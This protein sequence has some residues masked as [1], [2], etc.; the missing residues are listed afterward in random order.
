[1]IK[2]IARLLVLALLLPLLARPANAADPVPTMVKDINPGNEGSFPTM[3][4][5]PEITAVG[6]KVF[7]VAD[8]GSN[9]TELWVSD[10]TETGTYMVKDINSGSGNSSPEKLTAVG[11]K[12]YFRATDAISGTELWVSDGTETGTYMVK[13]INEAGNS[14]PDYLTAMNGLLYFSA[15]GG[16]SGTELWVSDGTETGT[17]MVK[18]IWGGSD[19]STPEHLTAVGN[20]LYFAASDNSIQYN[21][22]ELWVSN[23]TETGTT[24]VKDINDGD[25]SNP[26]E[27]TADGNTLYFVAT[28]NVTHGAELWVSNGT[29]PGTIM[30]KDINTSGSSHPENLTVMNSTLFFAADNGSTNGKELWASDGTEGGTYM[31]KDILD[32]FDNSDPSYL[33]VMNGKLY[34][35]A[36][37]GFPDYKELWVSDG[38][39]SGTYM[40]KD[41]TSSTIDLY[42]GPMNLTATDYKL[43]FSADDLSRGREL[44]VSDGT[45]AGTEMVGDINPGDSSDPYDLTVVG[46]KLF[47]FADD[48]T[49]GEELWV[50]NYPTDAPPPPNTAPTGI[51]LS[52]NSVAENEPVGTIVGTFATTDADQGDTF[53]YKTIANE[54]CPGPDDVSFTIEGNTLKTSEVFDYETKKSYNICVESTDSGGDTYVES[55]DIN[56]I[57]VAET[58]EYPTANDD[59]ATTQEDTAVEVSVLD[60]D[61]PATTGDTLT[62]VAASVSKGTATT[63]GTTVNYTPTL[64]FN[65]STV[66]SYT[67]EGSNGLKDSAAVNVTVSAVNDAP[68]LDLNGSATGI[69]TTA[70]FTKGESAA[71]LAPNVTVSDV[72]NTTLQSAEA[73][74]TN[75]KDGA[76]ERL[77]A[78]GTSTITVS[79]DSDSGKLSLSG[80]DTLANYRTVLATLAYSNTSTTPTTTTN[81][82]VTVSVSDGS[83]SSTSAKATVAVRDVPPDEPTEDETSSGTTDPDQDTTISTP[84]DSISVEVPTGAMSTTTTVSITDHAESPENVPQQS[85]VLASISVEVAD[86]QGNSVET[87]NEPVTIKVRYTD[88]QLTELGITDESKIVLAYYDEEQNAWVLAD[89]T[90]DTD[91]NIASTQLSAP[92]DVVLFDKSPEDVVSPS[93]LAAVGTEQGINLTWNYPEGANVRTRVE[94]REEAGSTSLMADPAWEAVATTGTGATSYVDSSVNPDN[95]YTYRVRGITS[96]NLVV[97]QPDNNTPSAKPGTSPEGNTTTVYLPLV[98][99]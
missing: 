19:S 86:D 48:G 37:G 93:G 50:Y 40:V 51:S 68:A 61:E 90:V 35:N 81:R 58:G 99:R 25:S 44:W 27:L 53:T 52:T 57:D 75:P 72:D 71:A 29:E 41:I 67:I 42:A 21:D 78:T 1:M 60:N 16:T 36:D 82:I 70:T 49:H 77:V 76:A 33:T 98:R 94:R 65:G 26:Y 63:N 64:N 46:D 9:G 20:N 39:E 14:F 24:R 18:D 6:D 84:D 97:T 80:E 69:N 22:R 91:A 28:D 66:I 8:D 17:K 15:Y 59:T 12:L 11:D 79:Y 5:L 43:Y 32:G 54:S 47:F 31:V 38:T 23:G 95:T 10:G 4:L 73:T 87:F 96:D 89:T 62:V 83:A 2:F 88:E 85:G 34:F 7:L 30:V 13:D 74:L 92:T 3:P 56:I 45:E 55:F